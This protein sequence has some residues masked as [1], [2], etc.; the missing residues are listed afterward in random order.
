MCFILDTLCASCVATCDGSR[1]SRAV[2]K[3]LT[4]G[5]W[6]ACWPVC[7]GRMVLSDPYDDVL[8]NFIKVDKVHRKRGGDAKDPQFL[9]LA[10]LDLFGSLTCMPVYQTG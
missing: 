4:W 6:K 1:F 3:I 9:T 2:L 8:L 10:I 5:T 7:D